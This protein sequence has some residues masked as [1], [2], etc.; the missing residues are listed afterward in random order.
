[1]KYVDEELG[2]ERNTYSRTSLR[3]VPLIDGETG[4]Q[5]EDISRVQTLV[6]HFY[7]GNSDLLSSLDVEKS[8]SVFFWLNVSES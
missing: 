6:R 2:R 8:W 1:L 7:F 4:I 5:N 3:T